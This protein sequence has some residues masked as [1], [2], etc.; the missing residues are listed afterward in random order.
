MAM[1]TQ[2]SPGS[3]VALYV[4]VVIGFVLLGVILMTVQEARNP[5]SLVV[6]EDAPN[7]QATTTT[8]SESVFDPLP[9]S[10]PA[11]AVQGQEN[12]FLPDATAA[13]TT[14]ENAKTSAASA[15]PVLV[16]IE[17]PAGPVGTIVT[18]R[19][20]YLV[21]FESDRDAWLVTN[22]G[23]V[24]YLPGYN[25]LPTISQSVP[26]LFKYRNERALKTVPI[27]VGGVKSLFR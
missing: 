9:R 10:T 2:D 16:S 7:D 24:G 12:Q 21:G 1:Q 8:E 5:T 13:T 18:L 14:N 4:A 25:N 15:V 20:D 27:E 6:A 17:P 22:E 3:L 23:E 19:G 11:R 26:Q